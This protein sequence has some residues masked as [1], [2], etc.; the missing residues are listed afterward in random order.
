MQEVPKKTAPKEVVSREVAHMEA[1]RWCPSRDN[2][3][4]E[5][6]PWR[7]RRL[8]GGSRV[9]D[10]RSIERESLVMRVAM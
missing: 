2:T 9:D 8:K 1:W 5:V 10:K 4:V 7:R 6:S 3:L